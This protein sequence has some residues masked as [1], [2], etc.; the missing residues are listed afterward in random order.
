MPGIPCI[1]YILCLRMLRIQD[2]IQ[3]NTASIPRNSNVGQRPPQKINPRK[4]E[5][6]ESREESEVVGF[7]VFHS[8]FSSISSPCRALTLPKLTKNLICENI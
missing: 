5:N 7:F 6:I 1:V 4:Y 3:L 2:G 8:S